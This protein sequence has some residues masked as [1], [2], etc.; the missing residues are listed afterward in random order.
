M[1][2]VY[3]LASS[4]GDKTQKMHHEK[5]LIWLIPIILDSSFAEFIAITQKWF[6]ADLH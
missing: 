6:Y 2:V 5:E 3:L 4:S 1:G